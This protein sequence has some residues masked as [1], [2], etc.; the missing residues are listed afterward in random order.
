M[1]AREMFRDNQYVVYSD[2]SRKI[3]YQRMRGYLISTIEID[4][5]ELTV[6]GTLR[7]MASGEVHPLKLTFE[8]IIACYNQIAEII[9]IKRR[10]GE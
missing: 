4:K 6:S 9:E 1:T 2:D 7:D 8:E 10:K 5:K 3:I